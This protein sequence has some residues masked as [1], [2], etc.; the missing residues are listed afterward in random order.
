MSTKMKLSPG[1]QNELGLILILPEVFTFR[2][3]S[4]QYTMLLHSKLP[5]SSHL[6]KSSQSLTKFK[7]QI[8]TPVSCYSTF[9]AWIKAYGHYKDREKKVKTQ[10]AREKHVQHKLTN[11]FHFDDFILLRHKPAPLGIMSFRQC[12]AKRWPY[13]QGLKYPTFNP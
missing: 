8:N 4:G 1:I 5:A 9:S 13:L 6:H 12:E 3:M 7:L 10:T 11:T 2:Q